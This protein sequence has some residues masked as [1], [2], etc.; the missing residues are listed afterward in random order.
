LAIKQEEPTFERKLE[1]T[2]DSECEKAAQIKKEKEEEN[3]RRQREQIKLAQSKSTALYRQRV[4]GRAGLM[5]STCI[6]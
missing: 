4:P 6:Y 1:L 2:I 3:A 5:G